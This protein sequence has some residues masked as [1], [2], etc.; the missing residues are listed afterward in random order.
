MDANEEFLKALAGIE[1]VV[2]EPFEYRLHYNE[3]GEITMCTMQQHPEHTK[4]V[5]V[6]KETYEKYYQYKVE[7]GMLKKIDINLGYSV[8]L[9]SSTTGYTVVRNHPA[10]LLEPGETYNDIEHYDTNS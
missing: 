3:L 5:V 1:L 10:L 2:P 8:Q 9:K 7:Q 4:Y 6:D